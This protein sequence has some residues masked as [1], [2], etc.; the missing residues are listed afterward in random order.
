MADN[1]EG[2]KKC[3][4]CAEWIQEE[5]IKCRHCW[6]MLEPEDAK[7]S[8]SSSQPAGSTP[9]EMPPSLT[10]PVGEIAGEAKVTV[11]A[12]D[13]S[14]SSS[15][16][17]AETFR[18][19]ETP[20]FKKGAYITTA[21]VAITIVILLGVYGVRALLVLSYIVIGAFGLAVFVGVIYF[22]FAEGFTSGTSSYSSASKP[23]RICPT[24]GSNRV[25]R[26]SRT[27]KV[28]KIASVG[29]FGLGNVHKIFK[30]KDCGYKW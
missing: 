27:W 3:P 8:E 5:A 26:F 18:F 23:S 22:G 6:S 30:C 15:E 11:E 21:V 10:E 1:H 2:M 12:G 16:E 29:I 13:M 14:D 17:S 19:W 9:E 4:Y 20:E 24:C 28:T 7:E 25:E